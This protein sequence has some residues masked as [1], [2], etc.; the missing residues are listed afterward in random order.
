MAPL[1]LS[2]PPGP[3]LHFGDGAACVSVYLYKAVLFSVVLC[4][5]DVN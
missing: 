5:F 2:V 1:S 3:A 4:M